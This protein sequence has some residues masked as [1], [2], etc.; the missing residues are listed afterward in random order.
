MKEIQSKRVYKCL[1]LED[2][3]SVEKEVD[4]SDIHEF[5]ES[6]F[7]WQ[8]AMQDRIDE[9]LDLGFGESMHF[10]FNRDDINT[11]GVIIRTR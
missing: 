6:G 7:E 5:E 2:T 10:Q 4:L 11:K 8:Y 9:I 1:W 3:E